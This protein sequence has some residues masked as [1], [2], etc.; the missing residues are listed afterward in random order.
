MVNEIYKA[1]NDLSQR[2]YGIKMFENV[3]DG[4]RT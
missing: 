1:M 2:K 3:D 4:E